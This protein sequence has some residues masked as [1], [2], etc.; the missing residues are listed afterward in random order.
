[1]NT[2]VYAPHRGTEEDKMGRIV[3][4]VRIENVVTPSNVIRCDALVDTG[5]V[6]DPSLW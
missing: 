2:L 6:R 1:M 5:A 3:T 4:A